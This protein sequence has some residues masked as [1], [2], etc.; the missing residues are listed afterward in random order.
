MFE[1]SKKNKDEALKYFWK[2]ICNSFLSIQTVLLMY[3]LIFRSIDRNLKAGF[4]LFAD[5][6][7]TMHEN[8]VIQFVLIDSII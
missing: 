2:Y 3:R 1:Q 5:S 7:I 6:I 8:E 4:T